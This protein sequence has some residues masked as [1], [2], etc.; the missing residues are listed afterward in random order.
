[1]TIHF[2]GAG[3]GAPDLITLR[4]ARLL[5][6]CPVCL[7]AGSIIPKALLTHCAPGTHLIDTAP[8]DLDA[9]EQACA[10]AHAAGQD[11]A[12]LHSG[13]LSLYSAVAETTPPAGAARDP[14]HPHPRRPRLRRRRRRARARAHRAR[15]RPNH[16]A[17]HRLP[18]RASAMPPGEQLAR[19]RRH[20]CHPRHPPRRRP[21]HPGTGR[22]HPALHGRLPPAPSSPAPPGRTSRSSAPPSA[23]CKRPA[24]SAP[25]SS[26]SG[27]P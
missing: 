11:V 4:G 22:T 15:H 26:S 25:P 21:A 5:A 24:S 2:I 20:R 12:R 7:Y 19:L 27:P 6:T 13:D 10:T 16:R 1:M 9:I 3:P 8:L 18:G 23:P 14:L 17:H